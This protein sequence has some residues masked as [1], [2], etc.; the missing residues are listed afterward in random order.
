MEQVV[1]SLLLAA[2]VA[3]S[4]F[5]TGNVWPHG[6]GIFG[7]GIKP[8]TVVTQTVWVDSSSYAS[9]TASKTESWSLT[10]TAGIYLIVGVSYKPTASATIWQVLCG[11]STLFLGT[12]TVGA[13]LNVEQWYLA[14]PPTGVQTVVVNLSS[15]ATSLVAG[16]ITFANAHNTANWSSSFGTTQAVSL[17]VTGIANGLVVDTLVGSKTSDPA[18]CGQTQVYQTTVGSGANKITGGGSVKAGTGNVD[19]VWT[20]NAS[21]EY[22]LGAVSV[23]P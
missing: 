5:S 16:A 18:V 12:Q 3:A 13:T 6:S 9:T 17:T 22:G 7:G 8:A 15:N 4:G 2:S 11:T 10:N 23:Y 14:N 1:A 21:S 20:L 19:M